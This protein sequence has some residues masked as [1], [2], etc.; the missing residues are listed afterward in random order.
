MTKLRCPSNRVRYTRRFNGNPL[1]IEL[2]GEQPFTLSYLTPAY[3]QL[4]PSA[5]TNLN[6]RPVENCP[7]GEPVSLPSGYSPKVDSVGPFP[8]RKIFAFEG[9]RYYDPSISGFDYSTV[10]NGSG[11]SGSPQGNF[12]SRGSAFIGSGENYL[13]EPNRPGGKPSTILKQISLRHGERMNA[14]MFDGHVELLDNLQSADPSYYAP[15]RSKLQF[16]WQC[17]YYYIGPSDNNPYKQMNAL[18]P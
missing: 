15:S 3:L 2:K 11:L 13:R 4:Y 12:L 5:I 1:Q 18:I 6:G 17:W 14:G 16:P 7:S 9:A 10:T 8:S